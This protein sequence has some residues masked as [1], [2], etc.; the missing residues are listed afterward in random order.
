MDVPVSASSGRSF[1][2]GFCCLTCMLA[3]TCTFTEFSMALRFHSMISHS[4]VRHLHRCEQSSH[5]R[6]SRHPESKSR[7]LCRIRSEARSRPGRCLLICR[8]AFKLELVETGTGIS[9][10]QID[11][12]SVFW[13]RVLWGTGPTRNQGESTPIKRFAQ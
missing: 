2:D 5:L 3:E 12:F 11:L 7:F 8:I 10:G 9:L 6:G 4:L 13:T 1:S